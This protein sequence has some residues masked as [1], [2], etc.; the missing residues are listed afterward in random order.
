[1]VRR[2]LRTETLPRR[3]VVSVPSQRSDVLQVALRPVTT[4]FLAIVRN[5]PLAATESVR[6]TPLAGRVRLDAHALSLALRLVG[7]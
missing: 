5:T 6:T 4:P 7:R 1:M 3:T 2:P